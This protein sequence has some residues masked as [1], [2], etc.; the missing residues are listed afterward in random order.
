M[1]L[2]EKRMSK[3]ELQKTLKSFFPNLNFSNLAHKQNKRITFISSLFVISIECLSQSF[4][5]H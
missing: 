3:S 5:K 4:K 1:I 2:T